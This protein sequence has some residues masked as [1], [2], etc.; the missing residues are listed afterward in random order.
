MPITYRRTD[1]T[2]APGTG[3][4]VTAMTPTLWTRWT[5]KEL[6]LILAI[7]IFVGAVVLLSVGLA[8]PKPIP[9]ASLGDTSLGDTSLGDTSLGVGLEWQCS[10]TLFLTSCTKTIRS[11]AVLHNAHKDAM[12]SRRA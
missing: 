12:C 6:T 9:S 10:K 5:R 4:G 8:R 3:T 1:G 7:V 11:A 2:Y